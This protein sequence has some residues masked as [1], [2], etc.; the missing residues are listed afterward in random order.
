[1]SIELVLSIA[2][3]VIAVL[4]VIGFIFSFYRVYSL[5]VEVNAM[6]KSTHKVQYMPIDP[7]WAQSEAEV[8]QAFEAA[9][10]GGPS[11]YEGIQ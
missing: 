9:D 6:K 11:E 1:M 8:N 5:D 3:I 10:G 2:A 7:N 4:T